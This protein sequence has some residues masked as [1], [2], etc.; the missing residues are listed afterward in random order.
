[1]KQAKLYHVINV[2]WTTILLILFI[3]RVWNPDIST[4][5]I[6]ITTIGWASITIIR[7]GMISATQLF[8]DDE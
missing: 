2:C 3:I 1:M 6:I 5:G 7:N 4:I 8:F